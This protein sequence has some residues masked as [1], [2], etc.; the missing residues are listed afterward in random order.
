[1]AVFSLTLARLR[2][3]R[4]RE[5]VAARLHDLRSPPSTTSLFTWAITPP[6]QATLS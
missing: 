2:G 3:R 5:R 1:M 4:L 6:I